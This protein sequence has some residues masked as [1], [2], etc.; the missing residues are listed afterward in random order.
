MSRTKNSF[1]NIFSVI[2]MNIIIGLIGFIKTKIFVSHLST[3]TYSINQLFYQIYSYITLADI[4][5]GFIISKNLYKAFAKN[6]REEVNK[7]YSTSVKF[8]RIIGVSMFLI[9]IIL[10]FIVPVFTQANL[11]STY[12]RLSFLLFVTR[13]IIDYFFIAPRTVI[14]A[15]QKSYKIN[16]LLK[17]IKILESITEIIL[18]LLGFDYLIILIPGIIITIIIDC[19]ICKKV[20]K[21]YSW[22]KNTHTFNKKHLK[23]TKD[24]L[25]I[26]IAG[27]LNTNTDIVLI[28]TFINPLSVVIYSSYCYITT[29]ITD[30]IYLI[31][32]AT[33]PSFANLLYGDDEKKSYKIFK[34]INIFFLFIASFVTIILSTFLTPFIK[35]W[36]GDIYAVAVPTLILFCVITFYN[37]AFR[38]ISMTINAKGLFEKT[39]IASILEAILN[40]TI[41]LVLVKN[42]GISGALLGTVL[43]RFLTTFIQNPTYVLK[44]IYKTTAL[45]Y[46]LTY[47]FALTVTAIFVSV[48]LF[49]IKL[50]LSSL[51]GFIVSGIIFALITAPI[52]FLIFYIF[53]PDFRNLTKTFSKKGAK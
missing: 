48:S 1:K 23:G 33:V 14:E 51:S 46:Y 44:H 30:T 36:L 40:L 19:I 38:A 50:D 29:F 7:I 5:F 20:F 31:A 25:S 39:K 35:L 11:D 9:S 6:D 42:I 18:L 53:S 16:Y 17:A 4:G 21:E 32:S 34:E 52:L 24:L 15:N 41:S 43:S 47:F 37:I 3:D 2:I 22:L 49:F 28:S 26:K 10:S 13:G 8:Y 45:N 27:I 12:I